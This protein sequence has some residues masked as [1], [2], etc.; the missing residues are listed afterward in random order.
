MRFLFV[1]KIDQIHQNTIIGTK[2]FRPDD[3][4]RQPSSTGDMIAPGVVSEAIGQLV[5]WLAIA[6]ND[7]TGRPVFLFA[8]NIEV[9]GPVPA[10]SE[11]R[12]EATIH[13]SNTETL[14]FSGAAFVDGNCVHKVEN[15][16]GYFMPLDQ[17]EDPGVTQR[18]YEFLRSAKGL[19]LEDDGQPFDFGV[20]QGKLVEQ[21]EKTVT[22]ENTIPRDAAF[23]ADH[24]PRFP[25]TPIV[26]INEMIGLAT[27]N[28]IPKSSPP[29]SQIQIHSVRNVKIR[30]F[31]RPGETCLTKVKVIETEKNKLGEITQIQTMAEILKGGKRIL[32]GLYAYG[33][34]VVA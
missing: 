25:V 34:A 2:R 10:G 33:S 13:E 8:D 21:S 4:M 9:R 14:V 18:R 6:G 12:L 28:L 20:L 23:F 22:V 16:S 31:I 17:L 26:M 11:V 15:C 19:Y 1:D 7:F 24:F 29:D 32:R 5:S 3:P 30:D 27:Q